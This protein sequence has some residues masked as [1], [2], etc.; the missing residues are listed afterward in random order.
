MSLKTKNN[1]FFSQGENGIPGERGAQGPPGPPGTRG[2]PGPAGTEG[3][4]VPTEC[5]LLF[6]YHLGYFFFLIIFCCSLGS[7]WPTWSPWR[8]RTAWL[9]GN[10]RRKRSFWKP[11]TKRGEGNTHTH[12]WFYADLM[13]VSHK[14]LGLS[15]SS[16]WPDFRGADCVAALL[17]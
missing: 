15:T 14:A 8:H 12:F 11:W 6:C 9:T 5:L 3:A 7:S 2:G 16:L 13:L 10:A 17:I 1:T 4:K